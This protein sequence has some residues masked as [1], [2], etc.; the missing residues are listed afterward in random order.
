M[1][2]RDRVDLLRVEFRVDRQRRS[3]GWNRGVAHEAGEARAGH[4]DKPAGWSRRG[5]LVRVRDAA[6]GDAGSSG[7]DHGWFATGDVHFELT[8]EDVEGFVLAVVD[9][10]RRHVAAGAG[11]LHQA[12]PALAL[13][14]V[15]E[16][17][18]QVMQEPQR[19]A[20]TRLRLGC[21]R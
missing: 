8:F 3:L 13:V 2:C 6:G 4:R 17:P 12:E 20:K 9:V 15:D 7:R 10:Q 14:A 21:D 19:L 18:R 5:H 1:P 16:D 11:H